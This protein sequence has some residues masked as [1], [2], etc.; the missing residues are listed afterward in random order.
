MGI[1]EDI[2]DRI[3]A[4]GKEKPE[5][6]SEPEEKLKF[7]KGQEEEAKEFSDSLKK[8]VYSDDEMIEN[9]LKKEK[10]EDKPE[11]KEEDDR[12]EPPERVRSLF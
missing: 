11:K 12:S 4:M 9:E 8:Y 6:R 5:E 10:K 3:K 7:E 2:K 1:F